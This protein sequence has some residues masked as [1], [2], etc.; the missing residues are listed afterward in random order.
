MHTLSCAFALCASLLA[1]EPK[2]DFVRE[3]API[4]QAHCVSCHGADKQKG[5]LRL[6]AREHA[7]PVDEEERSVV[8]GDVAA[9]EL[10]RRIELPDGDEERMPNEGPRLAPESVAVIKRWIEAG[11]EWPETGDAFFEAER[12]KLEIPKIEF[13]IEQPS[14]DAQKKIDEAVA[15]LRKKGVLCERVA[16]DSAALD[17]N[18]SLAGAQFG[19]AE[20]EAVAQLA[21]SLVWLNL[22]RTAVTDAGLA[23][24]QAMPHLRRLSIANTAVSDAGIA[25][26]GVMPKL[27]VLNAYGSKVGDAGLLAASAMPQ[28]RKVYAFATAVTENGAAAAVSKK[29]DLVVDRGEYATQRVAAAEREIA[30]RKRRE[31]P[32]NEQCIVSGDKPSKEHF[33]DVDGIRLVFCCGKCKK[34]YEDDPAAF[35]AKVDELR[36]KRQESA[37]EPKSGQRP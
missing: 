9:S 32:A 30:E 1:Q 22:G 29:S 25:A 14:A 34:K 6:D 35:A 17:C 3:V 2:V 28:L 24:I 19:D 23:R 36:K 4:L 15:L 7:F 27:E 26:L 31:E 21:P 37:A 13:G 18:A 5:D 8:A 20:M 12:K 16:V 33:V 11:A 10:V